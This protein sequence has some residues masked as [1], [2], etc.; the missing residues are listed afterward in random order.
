MMENTNYS[1]ILICTCA[2][3]GCKARNELT[4]ETLTDPRF[5]MVAHESDEGWILDFGNKLGPF[6]KVLCPNCKNYY[7]S[8][9]KHGRS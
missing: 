7:N 9:K 3:C 5:R 2:R 8:I 6:A 4:K 1:N